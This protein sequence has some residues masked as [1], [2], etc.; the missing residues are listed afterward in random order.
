MRPAAEELLESASELGIS[1][2]DHQLDQFRQYAVLLEE[3]NQKINLTSVRPGDYVRR[4]FIDSL[5]PGRM[6]DFADVRTLIDIGT[7][8]GFP[9]LPLKIAFP[10]LQV[11]LVDSVNKKVLFLAEVVTKLGLDKVACIH[12]R[13]EETGG[14][15]RYRETF[16]VATARAVAELRI[17]AELALPLVKVGGKALFLKAPDIEAEARDAER[18]I[19]ELGGGRLMIEP[20]GDQCSLVIIEKKY[21]SPDCYPRS[22]KKISTRPL[23]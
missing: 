2:S 19:E 15:P 18:A 7:G 23:R 21:P 6:E 8:A 13:A 17:L 9:G 10:H 5:N 22:F 16:D 20:A 12:A 14:D 1:L 11:T 4:H 3:W